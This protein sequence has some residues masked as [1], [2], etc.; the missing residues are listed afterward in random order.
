MIDIKMNLELFNAVKVPLL[1]TSLVVLLIIIITAY[2][3][4]REVKK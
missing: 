1:L 3:V 2:F 4:S